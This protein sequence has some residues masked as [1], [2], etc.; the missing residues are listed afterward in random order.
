[1]KRLIIG[2]IAVTLI[3]MCSSSAI[4]DESQNI[5]ITIENYATASIL[6]N[7]TTWS[8]LAP[9]GSNE[10]KPFNLDNNGSVEVDVVIKATNTSDW[11]I[12]STAGDDLFALKFNNTGGII[13]TEEITYTDVSFVQDLAYNE[14]TD[15]VLTIW[16]PV[17]SSVASQQQTTVTLTATAS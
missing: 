13:G 5:V 2:V 10:S 14:N 7:E 16:L 15:F 1:M 12:N 3:V 4:G 17:S 11:D 6:L 9:L 8:T